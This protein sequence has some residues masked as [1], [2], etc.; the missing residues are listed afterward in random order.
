[1]TDKTTEQISIVVWT[2]GD[3][4]AIDSPL[5]VTTT[6]GPNSM[7]FAACWEPGYCGCEDC[8]PIVG[9]GPTEQEAI[10]DYKNQ[11]EEKYGD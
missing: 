7:R 5:K 1:M 2:G 3:A 8:H 10:A 6:E 4:P 9:Y 11:W